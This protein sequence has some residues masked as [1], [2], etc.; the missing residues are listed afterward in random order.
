LLNG[1]NVFGALTLLLLSASLWTIG[2][3]GASYSAAKAEAIAAHARCLANVKQQNEQASSR[4]GVWPCW[5][6][7]LTLGGQKN[8]WSLL[9]ALA[10]PGGHQGGLYLTTLAALLVL[11]LRR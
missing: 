5:H 2:S 11:G 6:S 10:P 4:G 7:Q 8:S 9:N 1:L 3:T